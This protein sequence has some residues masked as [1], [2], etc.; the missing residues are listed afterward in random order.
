M[1][2]RAR[3]G[4]NTKINGNVFLRGNN[5][6]KYYNTSGRGDQYGGIYV[7]GIA[8]GVNTYLPMED[9]QVN[10]NIFGMKLD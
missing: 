1:F 4:K 9:T 5:S 10:D 3:S 8:N 6:G 2:I 7:T